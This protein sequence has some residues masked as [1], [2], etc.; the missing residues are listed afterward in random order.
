MSNSGSSTIQFKK[1]CLISRK[2]VRWLAYLQIFTSAHPYAIIF[3]AHGILIKLKQLVKKIHFLISLI[4][5]F[6]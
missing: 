3:I 6:K 2:I 1:Q 5:S 4:Y